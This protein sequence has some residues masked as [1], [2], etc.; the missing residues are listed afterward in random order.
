MHLGQILS[1]L[2]LPKE[3]LKRKNGIGNNKFEK[4]P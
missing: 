4:H 2:V 3:V 1:I